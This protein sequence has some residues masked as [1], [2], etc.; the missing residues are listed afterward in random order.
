MPLLLSEHDSQGLGSAV[1][2]ARRYSISAVLNL[3][4]DDDDDGNQASRRQQNG[5]QAQD[6]PVASPQ[7]VEAL[8]AAAKGLKAGQL[9]MA[10]A[11]C[12]V[13]APQDLKR[14]FEGVPQAKTAMLAQTLAGVER[15]A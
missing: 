8:V 9:R 14:A 13:E 5:R 3:V 12:G 6:G 1:T 15:E 4:A 7:D 11:A 10:L 2:Y